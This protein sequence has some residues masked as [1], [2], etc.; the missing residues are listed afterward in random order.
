M[1]H[2]SLDPKL[3][4]KAK[5]ILGAYSAGLELGCCGAHVAMAVCHS[6]RH[7]EAVGT[8]CFFRAFFFFIFP[9]VFDYRFHG[10]NFTTLFRNGRVSTLPN[11]SS[12]EIHCALTTWQ[13]PEIAQWVLFIVI[14]RKK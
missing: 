11:L 7:S 1:P 8:S 10:A 3:Y 2:C 12:A 13:T 4:N 9:P 6:R 5:Y 14:I